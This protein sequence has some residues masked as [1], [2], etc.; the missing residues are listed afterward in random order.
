MQL[1]IPGP[2]NIVSGQFVTPIALHSRPEK[3]S[4]NG[5]IRTD[6]P[7]LCQ[8]AFQVQIIGL[9]F[10][11]A[12]VFAEG[13]EHLIIENLFVFEK[14]IIEGTHGIDGAETDIKYVMQALWS[15]G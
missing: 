14:V 10:M 8:F 7:F 15:S 3:E 4:R 1:P 5:S 12:D 11:N 6:L 9:V 2:F 13:I